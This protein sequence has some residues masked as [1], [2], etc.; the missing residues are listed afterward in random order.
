MYIHKM[1]MQS[2]KKILNIQ[3]T[4]SEWP[5]ERWTRDGSLYFC[6]KDEWTTAP[7]EASRPLPRPRCS[8][9]TP[10]STRRPEPRGRRSKPWQQAG[11][12]NINRIK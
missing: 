1:K 3:Q 4:S 12:Q 7:A 10:S 9:T 8:P 5:W 11:S 2:K 6:V